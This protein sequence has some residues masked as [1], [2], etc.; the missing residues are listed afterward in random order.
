MC[1]YAIYVGSLVGRD[2][3]AV[4]ASEC[5]FKLYAAGDIEVRIMMLIHYI[6]KRCIVNSVMCGYTVC[7]G[8]YFLLRSIYCISYVYYTVFSLIYI[9]TPYFT[10]IFSLLFPCSGG[11]NDSPMDLVRW[12]AYLVSTHISTHHIVYGTT[13]FE[14]VHK[15]YV[16]LC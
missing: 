3:C 10:P 14:C 11:K 16:N 4:G 8:Y 15:L 7:L 12:K 2:M 1:T 5:V 6:L 9:L 13:L